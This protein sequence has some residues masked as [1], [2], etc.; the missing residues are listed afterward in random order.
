MKT[1]KKNKK[2]IDVNEVALTVY[3]DNEVIGKV[4]SGE[5]NQ[6]RLDINDD[7][8]RLILENID[9]HLLLVVDEMPET[10]HGCYLSNIYK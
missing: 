5:I 1:N 9:G 6:I 10:F 8:Y 4:R 2:E 7:N 3:V